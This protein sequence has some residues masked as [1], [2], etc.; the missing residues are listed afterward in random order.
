[1]YA[2]FGSD[3]K[4]ERPTKSHLILITDLYEGGNADE[5]MSRIARLI[6]LGVN[7]IVLLALTDAGRP[8][9]DPQLGG[10]VHTVQPVVR[11]RVRVVRQQGDADA[12]AQPA[13]AQAAR[14][15]VVRPR[16]GGRRGVVG[17]DVVRRRQ[18][19]EAP[20]SVGTLS[21]NL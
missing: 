16:G 12:A 21:A 4:I 2:R 8:S 7:V 11:V 18:R 6:R 15:G 10:A 5:L 13:D 1:M 17:V 14:V 19:A 3:D 20:Y 9:Y